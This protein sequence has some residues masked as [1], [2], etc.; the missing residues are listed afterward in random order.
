MQRPPASLGIARIR[1]FSTTASEYKVAV[2]FGAFRQFSLGLPINVTIP[3]ATMNGEFISPYQQKAVAQGSLV[4]LLV[5]VTFQPYR[6]C[7]QQ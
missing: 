3:L 7:E 6:C 4:N 2:N 1:I 5:Q